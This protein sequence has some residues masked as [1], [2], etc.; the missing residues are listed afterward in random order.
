MN[1]PSAPFSILLLVLTFGLVARLTRFVVDDTLTNPLRQKVQAL[2]QPGGTF[3]TT[4]T[5]PLSKRPTTQ[6]WV[7]EPKTLKH[8][9]FDF[10]AKVLDC[11]WCC[12][13][14]VS[15]ATLPSLHLASNLGGAW[16]TVYWYVAAAGTASLGAG[17]V[18]TWIY[19]KEI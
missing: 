13:V 3:R 10:L 8:K 14:W 19:S 4:E 11:G 2:S 12:S 1:D 7:Q 16:M 9:L 15:A 5:D 18:Q 17:L 6:A